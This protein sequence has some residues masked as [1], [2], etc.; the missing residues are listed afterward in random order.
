MAALNGTA[1]ILRQDQHRA[2]I[3]VTGSNVSESAA[4]IVDPSYLTGWAG[5]AGAT[6]L[7]GGATGAWAAELAI[8]SINWS[9]SAPMTLQWVATTPVNICNLNGSGQMRFKRDYSAFVWNTANVAGKTGQISI[10]GATGYYTVLLTILKQPLTGTYNSGATGI[11]AMTS[12]T[13]PQ[14]SGA[15]GFSQ[16]Y[17]NL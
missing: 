8:E 7:I 15:T 1:Q 6:G 3:L 12:A 9:T 17:S 11:Y 10:T 4:V 14:L 13:G 5:N 16:Q 2:T